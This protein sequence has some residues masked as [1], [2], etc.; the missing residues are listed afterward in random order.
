MYFQRL[1][2]LQLLFENIR[3]KNYPSYMSHIN[4]GTSDIHININKVLTKAQQLKHS[5]D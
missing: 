3:E 1:E 2:I 4:T 5:A